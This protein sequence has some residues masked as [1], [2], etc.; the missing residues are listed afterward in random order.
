MVW[1]YYIVERKVRFIHVLSRLRFKFGLA[2]RFKIDRTNLECEAESVAH[3]H[4][5]E[6]LLGHD[7]AVGGGGGGEGEVADVAGVQE[8]VRAEQVAEAAPV[9]PARRESPR[10]TRW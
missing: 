9:R 5:A 10:L 7:A 6:E 1:F 8:H 2:S 3:P 4:V